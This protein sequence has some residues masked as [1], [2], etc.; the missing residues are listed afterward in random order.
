VFFDIGGTLVGGTSVLQVIAE[1]MDGSQS[2]A[3]FKYLID[4]F[5]LYYLDENP[6]RFY[7]IK[8]LLILTAKEASKKFKLADISDKAVPL[9]RYQHLNHDYL[10]DDTVATLEELAHRKIKLILISDADSDVLVEQLTMFDIIKYFDGIIISDQTKAY[11]PSD[12]VVQ[13]AL[14]YCE[15]PYD[16]IL[17]VG[18]RD[19]DIN[20]ARKMG[21]KSVLINRGGKF[22]YK[23]D[24]HISSLDE[25]LR[26]D[27]GN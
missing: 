26:L 16:G 14:G 20:T 10:Y 19:V 23:A 2:E 13:K 12:K 4:R 24:Y 22:R 9:Y 27:T 5:M 3:I 7:S 15:K 21:V 11:K 25:I 17:F 6:P 1:E 18:D 8:E